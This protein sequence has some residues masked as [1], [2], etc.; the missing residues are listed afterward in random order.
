[1]CGICGALADRDS[2]FEV[3]EPYLVAMRDAM[4]HRG[5]DGCGVWVSPDRKVGFAHRRLAIIDLSQA[6]LQPMSNEDD[7]LWITFNGEIYNHLEIRA[8]LEATGRHRFKT[9]HADTEVILH[10][11]EEWGIDV[12][13]RLRGMFAFA[14]W[15]A[16]GKELWL[17]RDR[18]GIKPLY[19]SHH[20]GRL[21]F[22]SEIK[23]LL[24][25][26]EQPRK[27]NEEAFFHYLSF[28]AAPAPETLFEGIRKVPCGCLLRIDARGSVEE[29]RY[30]DVW[31]HTSPLV[32]VGED[33]IAER[34]LEE[35]RT[36]VRLR[37]ISDVPV[38][39]FLSGGIDS[40]TNAQL[41]G[42]GDGGPVKTFTIGYK[43]EY[44]TYQ[45]ELHY[46][47]LASE[48][49]RTDHHEL[50]LDIDDLMRFLPQMVHLQDEPIA[51]PVCFPLYSVSKLARDNGVIVCQVGEGADELFCG[52][53]RWGVLVKLAELNDLP[54]PRL[55]RRG[56][57]GVLDTV[58]R[59][60]TAPREWV[61]RSAEGLPIFWS[62]TEAFSETEKQALLSPRLRR[63][64]AGRTSWDAIQP[65]WER[66]QAKAWEKS[67]KNWM[68]YADMNLRLPELLL[69]KVDKMSMGVSLEARVPFLD[70]KFVEFAMSVPSE[71]KTKNG[72]LKYPL[73]KAVRGV[74]PDA[75][76]DRK[77]QGF[78]VPVYEW[79]FDRLGDRARREMDF[80]CENSD[81]FDPDA[82]RAAL[83]APRKGPS[84]WVLLNVAMWWRHNL[85]GEPVDV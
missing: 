34:L 57:L 11:F 80:L 75:L 42:E 1:M 21:T 72:E 19:Y 35:L 25:D 44:D 45:N 14:L 7:T 33:E 38:G 22:A 13:H 9:D 60:Q 28:L 47:R 50:L 63:E 77:K 49:A 56:F 36:A 71:L 54:V 66:Y 69:M 73:K 39:C 30:W 52:Y 51:D 31:D 37:K 79:L 2:S 17:V 68:A 27:V 84:Q 65:T 20:H 3:T 12:V 59:R 58:G 15:D 8:E 23:S 74:I 70:H 5:P 82:V 6:A 67:H 24:R 61:R 4:V 81:L 85:C 40:S 48:H 53:R 62:G 29:R 83:A 10:G 32:G 64:F 26:P 18:L 55:L 76:I 16:R 41:F 78:G 43:G 46:A